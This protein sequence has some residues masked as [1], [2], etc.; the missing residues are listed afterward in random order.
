MRNVLGAYTISALMDQAERLRTM[1]VHLAKSP[2]LAITQADKIAKWSTKLVNTINK[3]QRD[4]E[5]AALACQKH[6]YRKIHKLKIQADLQKRKLLDTQ[7]LDS[8]R[9][10][11]ANFRLIFSPAR[12]TEYCSKKAISEVF[13]AIIGQL[14][15]EKLE[16]WPEK[17]LDIMNELGDKRPISTEFKALCVKISKCQGCCCR[18]I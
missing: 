10:I 6:L 16:E 15:Q 9:T 1:S 8:S 3:I 4:T 13:K 5:A 11:R 17:I 18:R 2:K 14:K 7:E 12:E